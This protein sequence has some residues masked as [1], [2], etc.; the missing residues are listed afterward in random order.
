MGISPRI[1]KRRIKSVRSTGKIM[2][3]MELVAASKMRKAVQ[4]ALAS[5]PYATMIRELT[6]ELRAALK[7]STDPLLV[8]R[9][10]AP[11]APLRTL[12]V[13]IA[14]DRGLC[15]GYNSQLLKRTAEFFRGRPQD[16]LRVVTMGARAERGVRRQTGTIIASFG[17]IANHISFAAAEPMLR[18]VLDEYHAHRVDR[19]FVVYTDFKSAIQ[20]IPTAMQLLPVLPEEELNKNQANALEMDQEEESEEETGYFSRKKKPEEVD[21]EADLLFE[22]SG[23]EVLQ[24]LLPRLVETRLYQTVLESAAS[25]HSARMMAMRSAGEAARDM[26]KDLTLVLNQARQAAITQEISEI[27]AGK[28]AIE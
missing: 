26:V 23:P 25:E 17:S 1:I 27:S 2:K 21:P 4:F 6:D 16:E 8:G 10:R 15:G 14:S 18:F 3:A 11:G 28:A 12:V 22:P 20:Q 13:A 19:V 5:R 7:T 24:K 9:K